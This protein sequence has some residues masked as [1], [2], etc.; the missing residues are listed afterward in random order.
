[1]RPA[2]IRTTSRILPALLIGWALGGSAQAAETVPQQGFH[3][4]EAAVEAMLEGFRSDDIET[5]GKIFGPQH[6]ETLIGPDRAAASIGRRQ[7]YEK[8]Q[9]MHRLRQDQPNR[10]ILIIGPEAWPFPIP[11]VQQGEQW[12]FATDEG[13]DEII[14][15]RI[16]ENELNAILV[17]R[18][19]VDAQV[20]YSS[21]DRDGDEVLEYAQRLGSSPGKHDGL[22]WDETDH[23]DGELS[24]F[25]P[26]VA[27][28]R[29]YIEAR[30]PG[31]PFK[32]YYF[33]ILSR[34]GG[35]PPGGAYDY[36]IN[37]N[38]IAGFALLAYP[39]EHGNSGVMSFVVNH[40]GKIYQTNLGPDTAS[41]A[42]AVELYD[43]DETWTLV[44]E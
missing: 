38:M 43:P 39:A 12:F 34:Q 4:P 24:P 30:E 18:A 29:E 5:L 28:A 10:S 35:N 9:A 6:V 22:Y 15:R 41:L 8:A 17:A 33:K 40:Q 27:E 2:H 1:M 36:V 31:A 11:I 37:G 16:G 23:P 3:S 13:I 19:Y 25:G 7:I 44:E 14:N 32:G 26:L 21:K 20:Q 42:A